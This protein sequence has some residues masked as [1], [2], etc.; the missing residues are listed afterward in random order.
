M[1]GTAQARRAY[2]TSRRVF[3]NVNMSEHEPLN[4]VGCR[5]CGATPTV[6]SHIIPSALM[7][8]LRGES[9]YLH[10]VTDSMKGTKFLQS[11]PIDNSILCLR[12]E[13][14]TQSADKYGIEFCRRVF[15][16]VSQNG[17]RAQVSNP[18]PNLLVRFA[19]LTVWRFCIS[20]HGRG[21]GALG[22]YG[23]LLR[24]AIFDSS[25]ELPMM[26]L[27]RNHLRLDHQNE[28]TVAIAPFPIRLV[29]IRFWL[30]C[31]SGVQFYLKL[32]KRPLPGDWE[33]FAANGADPATLLQLDPMLTRD[34][35]ILQEMMTNMV[36]HR[37][38]D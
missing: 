9:P 1:N 8:D 31:V 13:Q 17:V 33:R 3:K 11:G 21:N 36:A 14:Q 7:G 25:G 29:G 16:Q 30:F 5:I 24:T 20:K 28:S 10:E 2:T 35:P 4:T 6:R 19:C 37:D 12:H 38:A 18:D 27:A 22:P 34:V 32:D 26:F 23:E 15:D